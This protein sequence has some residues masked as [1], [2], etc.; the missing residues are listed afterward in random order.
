[1]RFSPGC[2]SRDSLWPRHPNRSAVFLVSW[3]SAGRTVI[4]EGCALAPEL[5]GLGSLVVLHFASESVLFLV[6]GMAAGVSYHWNVATYI[7]S[8][9]NVWSLDVVC[10]SIISSACQRA[11]VCWSLNLSYCRERHCPCMRLS[12]RRVYLLSVNSVLLFT[13]SSMA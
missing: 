2:G 11:G 4:Q 9:W 1:M 13:G 7:H 10:S 6:C 5:T 8:L 12:Y 3:R